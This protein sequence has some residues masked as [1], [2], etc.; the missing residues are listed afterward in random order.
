MADLLARE[1]PD[2]LTAIY[3]ELTILPDQL[4]AT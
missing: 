3:D 4:P 2:A 1:S